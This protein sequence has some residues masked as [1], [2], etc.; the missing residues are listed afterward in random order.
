M[1]TSRQE[2]FWCRPTTKAATSGTILFLQAAPTRVNRKT[3]RKKEFLSRFLWGSSVHG[4]LTPNAISFILQPG[5]LTGR[6]H[7]VEV[8]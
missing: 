5:S 8:D 3:V 2:P 6:K 4:F 7:K 1:K